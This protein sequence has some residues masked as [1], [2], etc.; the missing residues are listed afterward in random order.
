SYEDKS[1]AC[2][3]NFSLEKNADYTSKPST[4]ITTDLQGDSTVV[5]EGQFRGEK[6]NTSLL[7]NDKMIGSNGTTE[8]EKDVDASMTKI[9]AD[10]SIGYESGNMGSL[11][12]DEQVSMQYSSKTKCRDVNAH[13][14]TVASNATIE[15]E[16]KST[17]RT[18]HYGID[19]EGKGSL[20]A[21][22][23][24]FIMEGQSDISYKGKSNAYGGNFT[25][26]KEVGYRTGHY[27]SI[28]TDLQ[29]DSTVVEDGQLGWR[30][31]TAN[32]KYDTELIGTNGATELSKDFDVDTGTAPNL[33]VT[34]NIGY[35]SGDLGSL[36]QSEHVGMCY[37]NVS[38][39]AYGKVVATNATTETEAEIAGKSLH[40]GIDAEGNGSVSAGVDASAMNGR[41]DMTCRDASNAYGGNFTFQKEIGYNK[42]P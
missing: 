25:L 32:L 23:D 24:A 18:L 2:G 3:G 4:S 36:S 5:V 34:K 8:L 27:V 22:V 31:G 14:M 26:A 17:S 39:N 1:T 6:D 29:G 38:V 11:S 13:S 28:T 42:P 35:K 40:Y 10:K 19:T 12:H 16:A 9:D 33:N 30:S 15:T 37:S 20:S 21:D 41:T 7:Y